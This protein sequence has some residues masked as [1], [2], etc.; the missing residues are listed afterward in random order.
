M[1]M[2]AAAPDDRVVVLSPCALCEGS[3]MCLSAPKGGRLSIAYS[4]AARDWFGH[5]SFSQSSRQSGKHG[6]VFRLPFRCPR[7]VKRAGYPTWRR[8]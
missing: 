2:H 6:K 5:I 1:G 3:A 4:D 8:E 7:V